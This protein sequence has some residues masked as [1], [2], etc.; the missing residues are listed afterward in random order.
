[1]KQLLRMF[2][3]GRGE[4]AQS[5]P[6]LFD[7]YHARTMA[8]LL[9]S[10]QQPL[11][12]WSV[13]DA[14]DSKTAP[15]FILGLLR[16]KAGLRKRFP[17]AV[18]GGIEFREWVFASCDRLSSNAREN[19]AAAFDADLAATVREFYLH[20]PEVQ[21]RY[22]LGLLP[23]GQKRFVKW[24]LGKGRSQHALSDEQLLWFLH[25]TAED[26]PRSIALTYL[27]NPA[28]Q[29]RFPE[30][31]NN[32][33]E[34]L[35][36][37]RAE[38]PKYRPLHAV[39]RLPLPNESA[40]TSLA[41]VNVLAHFCYTS[42]LQQAALGY[43]ESLQV[44]G[45]RVTCRDVPAG[46]LT[47]LLPREDWLATETFPITLTN[48][49]PAPH[50]ENRYERAGLAK[51]A[52]VMRIAYWAWELESVPPEWRELALSVDEIWAPSAFVAKA[53]RAGLGT[54]VMEMLPGLS[55]GEVEQVSRAKLRVAE[56]DFVFLFMFDMLSDF[57]RKNPLAVIRAFRRAF[58]DGD[59]ATLV[60]KTSRGASDPSKLE[61]LR[62]E[63]AGARV[64]IIDELVPRA[65]AYGFIAMGDCIVSL[66]RSEG[67]GM[68]LAEAML[69][70]KPVI[71]TGYSGNL[72][73]MNNE[74]SLLVDHEMIA[75]TE[76]G[77]IYQAGNR[78]ADPS[79]EQAAAYMRRLFEN[80]AEAK[81]LGWRGQADVS[82]QLAPA[83]AGARMKVRID[84]LLRRS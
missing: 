63:A 8:A 31:R 84:Q 23:V 68:L 35:A 26:L 50:F 72:A 19:V 51:R 16:D 14:E 28:W 76:S 61:R 24:L 53:L 44:A 46:V 64:L 80:R 60:I 9:D 59:A 62:L 17:S 54:P 56:E 78:W 74:N 30:L 37:L 6:D 39:E 27:I 10:R 49:A 58:A 20:N 18:S 38:F 34:L 45:L 3:R 41:G 65:R 70:G 67:F 4:Q 66:H 7:I 55:V 47:E 22:P 81:A 11:G 48:V 82:E 12:A 69:L 15:R 75:I 13:S 42:G 2:R 77:P 1:M 33:Q 71:G 25:A 36:W 32:E 40:A 83:P 43:V 73:F 5:V 29:T 21:W 57:E 52:G 79:V